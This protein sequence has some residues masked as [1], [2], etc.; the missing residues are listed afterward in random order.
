MD[1]HLLQNKVCSG[2]NGSA[3]TLD[4]IKIYLIYVE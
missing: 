3:Y 1:L 4:K 2:L